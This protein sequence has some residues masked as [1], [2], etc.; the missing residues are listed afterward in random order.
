M[1]LQL[2]PR[3]GKVNAQPLPASLRKVKAED[4]QREVDLEEKREDK[5]GHKRNQRQQEPGEQ[6]MSRCHWCG[7]NALLL[8]LCMSSCVCT[9]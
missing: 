4:H 2:V 9:G 5:Y 3:A 7:D 1:A 8:A 6:V